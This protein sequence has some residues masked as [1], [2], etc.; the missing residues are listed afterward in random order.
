MED[1][2]KDID[3]KYQHLKQE[4]LEPFYCAHIHFIVNDDEDEND[5]LIYGLNAE[6]NNI[7][8]FGG[9]RNKKPDGQDENVLETVLREFSEETL[10][11][12][13]TKEK[14]TKL[15][16]ECINE[17]NTHFD[18]TTSV[19]KEEPSKGKFHW[20][21]FVNAKESDI[22][23]VDCQRKFKEK[24]EEQEQNLSSDQKENKELVVV[25]FDEVERKILAATGK[26]FVTDMKNIHVNDVNGRSLHLRDACVPALKQYFGMELYKK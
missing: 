1:F 7:A 10:D 2:F 12:I 26:G 19:I 25:Q 15:L 21:F 6:H 3:P 8:S 13:C 22:D 9:L 16:K 18:L 24:L 20:N 11:V 4:W 17:H 14:I 5:K 23:I